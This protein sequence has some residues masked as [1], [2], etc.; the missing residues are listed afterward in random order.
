M[1][2]ESRAATRYRKSTRVCTSEIESGLQVSRSGHH[3][4]ASLTMDGILAQRPMVSG[5]ATSETVK[6]GMGN[7]LCLCWGPRSLLSATYDA[8]GLW[9][10]TGDEAASAEAFYIVQWRGLESPRSGVVRVSV[11][12]LLGPMCGVAESLLK[13][14]P[15]LRDASGQLVDPHSIQQ[16]LTALYFHDNGTTLP[17]FVCQYPNAHLRLDLIMA[18]LMTVLTVEFRREGD[19]GCW[20]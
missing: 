12:A 15:A 10:E 16:D 20:V 19:F 14:K 13:V 6:I 1:S 18:G 11:S 7:K 4:V 5:M 8:Y 9:H 3:K 17:Q 2:C